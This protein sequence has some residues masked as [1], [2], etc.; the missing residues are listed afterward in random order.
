MQPAIVYPLI[1]FKRLLE[2]RCAGIPRAAS[3]SQG[4]FGL[5]APSILTQPGYL[6]PNQVALSP[7]NW[8]AEEG[9]AN[10][11]WHCLL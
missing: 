5:R 9:D 11:A 8:A 1:P 3:T 2:K 7:H 4:F 6:V 10:V